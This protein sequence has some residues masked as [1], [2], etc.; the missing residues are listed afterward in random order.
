MSLLSVGC[1][2]TSRLNMILDEQS[3]P[4]ALARI[5]GVTMIGM[6]TVERGL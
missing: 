4:W 3:H 2:W 1:V 6:C 5:P